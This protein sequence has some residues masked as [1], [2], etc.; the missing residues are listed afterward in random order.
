MNMLVQLVGMLLA[1]ECLA[2][3]MMH[4]CTW[5]YAVGQFCVLFA[6]LETSH[7]LLIAKVDRM[8]V[9]FEFSAGYNKLGQLLPQF[10]VTCKEMKSG[11][12]TIYYY[13]SYFNRTPINFCSSG[14][15]KGLT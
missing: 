6:R 5:R 9:I 3:K 1:C 12:D 14:C 8:V 7:Q 11:M 2:G 10:I 15:R 13:R 4:Q